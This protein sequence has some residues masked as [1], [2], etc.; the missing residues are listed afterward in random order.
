LLHYSGQGSDSGGVLDRIVSQLLTELDNLGG[1]SSS[2]AADSSLSSSADSD[3]GGAGAS[4]AVARGAAI[5]PWDVTASAL[6]VSSR[7]ASADATGSASKQQPVFVIGATNR[8]DLLDSSL[9]RPGRLDRS[10]YL[11]VAMDKAAQGK[12][13]R[14]LTRKFVL[15]P[16]LDIDEVRH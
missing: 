15:E 12:I 16:G 10:V 13:L 5:D 1:D 14:A 6:G 4:A 11:G 2:T 3:S 7:S 9:L 8:P